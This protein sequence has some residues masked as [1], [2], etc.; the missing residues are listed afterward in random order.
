MTN[1]LLDEKF[2]ELH[3]VFSRIKALDAWS[4]LKRRKYGTT[5]PAMVNIAFSR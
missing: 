2:K 1:D 5:G 3:E 4:D